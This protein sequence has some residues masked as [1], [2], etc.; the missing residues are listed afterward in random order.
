MAFSDKTWQAARAYYEANLSL[1]E[2]TER[3]GISPPG[4]LKRAKSEQ[5]EKG[6]MQSYIDS[7]VNVEVNRVNKSEQT[8]QIADSIAYS[9]AA[10]E[11]LIRNAAT[12]TLTAMESLRD[13]GKTV[14]TYIDDDG[15][16][17]K[18]IRKIEKE[19]DANSYKAIVDAI[20]K[21]SLTLGVNQ[22]HASVATIDSEEKASQVPSLQIEFVDK[23]TS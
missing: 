19:L 11:I 8:L 4:I 15:S 2:I 23:K 1:R 14:E 13:R 6:A 3:T 7:K 20:D 12:K 9:R 21:A 16:G 18:R 10:A 17:V 22:R 5:W